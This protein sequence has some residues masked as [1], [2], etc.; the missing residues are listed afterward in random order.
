M[1]RSYREGRSVSGQRG[2]ALIAIVSL[3]VLISAYLLVRQLNAT[4]GF[5]ADRLNHNAKVLNQAK[6]ATATARYRRWAASPGGRSGW[7][8]W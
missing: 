4:T 5:T 6:Q 7:T 1:P 8:N 3:I 2:F